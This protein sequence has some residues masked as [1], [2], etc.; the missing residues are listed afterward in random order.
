[1]RGW[2]GFIPG[3]LRIGKSEDRG[4]VRVRSREVF[5][6]SKKAKRRRSPGVDPPFI[7]KS[8]FYPC[9]PGDLLRCAKHLF[10]AA[11]VAWVHP[12]PAA[13]RQIRRQRGSPRWERFQ[14]QQKQSA[15]T[16][17][18]PGTRRSLANRLLS[19]LAPCRIVALR[20]TL[21]RRCHDGWGSSGPAANRKIRP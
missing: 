15:T 6:G 7:G 3:L 12:G 21:V 8:T 14:G 17:L 9:P 18:T 5:K 13:S 20:Q 19:P 10:V 4:A 11:M 2:L 16:V 1:V